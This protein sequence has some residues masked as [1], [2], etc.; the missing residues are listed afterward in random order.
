[1][2]PTGPSW[3]KWTVVGVNGQKYSTF[4]TK[5]ADLAVEAKRSESPVQIAYTEGKY[6]KD[7]QA[8]TIIET[9]N[10]RDPGE[11]G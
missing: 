11:E 2:L 6:G 1:M 4:D 3:T 10:E 9:A 8:L 7:I 5:L